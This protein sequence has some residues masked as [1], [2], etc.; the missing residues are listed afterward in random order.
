MPP[1]STPLLC[2]SCLVVF[3]S[4]YPFQFASVYALLSFCQSAAVR[5][6]TWL[7]AFICVSVF[8]GMSVSG[9]SPIDQTIR[10]TYSQIGRCIISSVQDQRYNR[11]RRLPRLTLLLLLYPIPLPILH[12]PPLSPSLHISPFPYSTLCTPLSLLLPHSFL[13]SFYLRHNI[14]HL[15]LCRRVVC[16]HD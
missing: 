8:V 13:S 5:L 16:P 14:L 1:V 7:S 11:P 9:I 10:Q 4:L 6:S 12:T 3:V 2:L 15:S